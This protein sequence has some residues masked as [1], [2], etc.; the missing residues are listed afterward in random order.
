MGDT[1]NYAR[2]TWEQLQDALTV[3]NDEEHPVQLAALHAEMNR[4]L[5]QPPLPEPNSSSPSHQV[6]LARSNR[7]WVWGLC[8]W[9]WGFFF[10]FIGG[11]LAFHLLVTR[12]KAIQ[13]WGGFYAVACGLTGELVCSM[14]GL[15]IGLR[16][17]RSNST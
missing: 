12:I 6:A 15:F 10:G 11:N 14:V 4:R 16:L 8:G 1:P 9:L 7:R 2:Y 5:H 17:F 13:E 3:T